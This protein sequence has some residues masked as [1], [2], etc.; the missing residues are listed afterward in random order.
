M[1]EDGASK[2]KWQE[3]LVLLAMGY[4]GAMRGEYGLAER[5]GKINLQFEF[6]LSGGRAINAE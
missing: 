4:E 3:L 1:R 2:K 6:D 5:W